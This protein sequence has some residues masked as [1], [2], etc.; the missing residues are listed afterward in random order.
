MP[1]HYLPPLNP[2]RAFEAS[3]RLL[4]ITKAAEELAVTPAAV[5]RQVKTLEVYLGVALFERVHGRLEL[6]SAGARYLSELMPIF[7]SLKE[8][9][10]VLRA[11][12]RRVRVLRIRSPATFAVRWLIPRLASF[13]KL[14]SDI[15]VQLTTSSAPLNFEREK[16]DGG[17][18]LGTGKWPRMKVQRLVPNELIPVAAPSR[19]V[20]SQGKLKGETLLHSMARPEDWG[21]W[22]KAA[23]FADDIN[24]REMHYE[25]SLLAY[26]A[27]VEGHGV[28][29]AQRALVRRELE[30]G[31]LVTPFRTVLD[32]ASF[33]YYFA[34][35]VERKESDEMQAFRTWLSN[36]AELPS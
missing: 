8:A 27:A 13:H 35:P 22:L 18:E 25:T 21:L 10:T 4:S 16:I 23:G 34:W 26:Q 6:T 31:S 1:I 29:I 15:D 7:S 17:I 20:K 24:R 33:T 19:K 36:Q 32:R 14:H 30:E 11:A 12:G 3:G 28:A 9:T 5:S 2:A